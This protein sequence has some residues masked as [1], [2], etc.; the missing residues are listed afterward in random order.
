MAVFMFSLAG[1][2]P[3]AG[4][5]GKYFIFLAA[6]RAHMVPLAVIGVLTSVIACYYYLRIIK[7]MYFDD[8]AEA[9][10]APRDV[11]LNTV[12]ALTCAAMLLFVFWP[13]PLIDSAL[14]AAQSLIGG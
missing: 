8:P 12:L 7:F 5:F 2:P 11:G 14:T 3:L 13:A 4:F 1:V 10:E 6:V 9:H